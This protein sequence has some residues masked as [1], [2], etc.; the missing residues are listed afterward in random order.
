MCEIKFD[1]QRLFCEFIVHIS[2]IIRANILD[3]WNKIPINFS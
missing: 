3:I 2:R 1:E